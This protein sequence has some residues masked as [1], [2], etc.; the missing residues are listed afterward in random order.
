MYKKLLIGLIVALLCLSP[1]AAENWNSFQ[2]GIDHSGYRDE[3]S[4]FVTNLWTFNM[5]SPVH[6]S[7]AIYKDYIYYVSNDGILKA[8][9]MET[10]EEEWNLDLEAKT[11]SSPII[12]S[13]RL[14]IG[15]EDGLK[16][17]NINSHK[18]VW[19]YDCD[20]VASAPVYHDDII[21]F[22]SDDGHLYGVNEDGKVKF[23]KKLGDELRTSP[24]VVDNTIYVG[25]TGGKMYSIDT[26]ESKN[27][28]FTTGDEILSSPAYVNKT[29]IFGSTDGSVY[30]LKKSDGDLEWKVDLNDKVISSP[31]V[32]GHDNNVFI[33]SDEGNMTCLD[34]RDGTVKWSHSTGDK[35]QSTAAIKD[36]LVAFGSNNG[37]LYV[38]NKYTGAEEFTYNP[39]TILFNSAITS[40]PV[41]NGNSLF[42]GDDSGNVYSLNINK[43]EVPGSTQMFYS[44]AVLIIVIIVAIVF[45]RKVKGRK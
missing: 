25:S 34:V 38:L 28:E 31:T 24:I 40:S 17:V 23:D 42:F 3:G 32:D 21:Y 29:I 6:S 15:C 33:G 37:Y 18:V 26:D 13:N 8:I 5:E 2:G 7:P 4:D 16:A 22:G 1:I 45:V 41:I 35:V 39:G 19:D 12:H 9:D 43:Y 10:G 30:C 27:W 11:N 20:N 36:N 44:I 14:Y